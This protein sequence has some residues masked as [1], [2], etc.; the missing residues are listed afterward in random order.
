MD[1]FYSMITK[2]IDE[3]YSQETEN[4]DDAIKGMV[5]AKLKLYRAEFRKTID[6]VAQ[7]V[8]VSRMQIMRWEA[9]KSKPSQL[10]IQK[11]KE[12]KII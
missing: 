11:L 5:A 10:A 1:R 8:G 12:L 9:R 2:Q 3:H 4:N 6:E 7:L